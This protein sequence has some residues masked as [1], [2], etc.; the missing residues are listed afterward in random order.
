[1]RRELLIII[2]VSLLPFI[3][4]F[5]TPLFFYTQDG[6]THLARGGAFYKAL[7]DG[8]L[9]VRWVGDLNY[10]YG[11]PLFDF[12][13]QLPYMVMSLFI[14]IG[15]GLVTSLKITALI[16][17]L[18]SGIFMY[19]FAQEFFK[20]QKKAL[21][22]TLFYQFFPFRLVEIFVR[23]SIGEM[24][25]FTFLPLV[26][27]GIV[28]F[29]NK[30]RISALIYTAFGTAGMVLSHL[31]TGSVFLLIAGVFIL[32][33]S[34]TIKKAAAN[35]LAILLGLGV[36][37]YYLIPA[38]AD[39]K[40]TYGSL[41]AKDL[42]AA[43]FVPFT[44]FFIPNILNSPSLRMGDVP[45]SIGLFHT[46][47]L[48]VGCWLLFHFRKFAP[49]DR[50]LITYCLVIAAVSFFI[51][52]PPSRFLWQHVP[53]FEQFQFPW[54]FLGAVGFATSLLSIYF[55][56]IP[57]FKKKTVFITLLILVTI[58]TAWYWHPQL[59]FRN[60]KEADYWNY[61][62]DTTYFG[63]TNLIW[64][65]GPAS[66][67]PK[68]R[69][70]VIDGKASI[71]NIQKKSNLHT[72][73]IDA[74]TSAKIVDHNQFYPGWKVL[75]DGQSVPIQF[76]DQLHRGEITYAVPAGQHN[77]RV[78]FSET[79]LRLITDIVSIASVLFIFILLFF[80]RITNVLLK[81]IK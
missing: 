38:L 16:S 75:V 66:S 20:D 31:A 77:I 40:Y 30:P 4:I 27:Y 62:L 22:V 67:Y 33:F 74:K 29:I 43:N 41:F 23:G 42:Y 46:I 11:M 2:L 26:L 25:A 35:I 17:F 44:H 81:K 53:L 9:P 69:V 24:F 70:E 14:F 52:E 72:Y 58:T 51:M 60:I 36:S 54:R 65:A 37:A 50:K 48:L 47:A 3:F 63:E 45:I 78:V 10:G 64:S 34:D 19:L 71:S 39:H 15:L 76:Q 73:L 1:M 28:L 5:T 18:F 13:F 55:L 6:W 59:G 79:I 32:L 68:S 56:N 80:R 7:L 61:P 8:Q 21:L 12:V 57:F 49:F